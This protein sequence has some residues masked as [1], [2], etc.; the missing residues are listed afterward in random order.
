MMDADRPASGASP[1][2]V[3]VE[4]TPGMRGPQRTL[5]AFAAYLAPRL[6]L[7][8]AIPEG[9]VAR[10]VRSRVPEAEVLILP[11]HRHRATSW[12]HGATALRSSLSVERG[13]TLFHVN[14]LSALNLAAPAARKLR[15]PVFAHFHASELTS[16]SRLFLRA[17]RRWRVPVTLFPVSGYSRT[18]LEVAGLG[19]LVGG[20]LPNPV[21][22]AGWATER[23]PHRPFRVGYVGSKSP[24]K[25]LHLLLG[26]AGMLR[27]EEIEWHIFGIDPGRRPT[28]YVVRCLRIAERDGLGGRIRWRGKVTDMRGA[29]ADVDALLIPSRRESQSRVALEGMASGLPVVA[30][31]V[32]GLPEVVREGVTGWLF[33]PD[34][35]SAGAAHLR[36]LSDDPDLWRR[37]SRASSREAARFDIAAVGAELERRYA[38][39]MG[40]GASVGRLAAR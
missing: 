7:V 30:T 34:R 25:G 5:L 26:I 9:F 20:T 3:M 22:A 13:R 4:P 32:G 1:T 33:D 36:R 14:G 18:V 16:R 24:N 19:E 6:R 23:G 15:A 39:L 17:W 8:V 35:P 10:A 40:D 37:I 21:D 28:P 2:V 27:D 31:R 12:A 38:E 29:Y 11:F